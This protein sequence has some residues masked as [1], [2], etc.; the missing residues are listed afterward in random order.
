MTE[1]KK[2]SYKF[3]T[4]NNVHMKTSQSDGG[5]VKEREFL[6]TGLLDL[7]EIDALCRPLVSFNEVNGFILTLGN[8]SHRSHFD[9]ESF[10]S[11]TDRW[12]TRGS[13]IRRCTSCHGRNTVKL[14]FARESRLSSNF[15]M[16]TLTLSFA[17]N[18]D[19][20]APNRFELRLSES[21]LAK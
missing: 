20:S 18:R 6:L 8:I 5:D 16:Q 7:L 11:D 15:T 10:Q 13:L 14:L 4:E 9:F 19:V 17:E 21:L 12:R 3:Y 2:V 1:I